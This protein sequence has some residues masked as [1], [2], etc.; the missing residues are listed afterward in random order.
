LP[1]S[2]F[3][4]RRFGFSVDESE[5]DTA[6]DSAEVHDDSSDTVI[7]ESKE[8]KWRING[9][10]VSELTRYVVFEHSK[11]GFPEYG[12]IVVEI[13]YEDSLGY[14]EYRVTSHNVMCKDYG[15]WIAADKDDVA[16]IRDRLIFSD[17]CNE[18]DTV[19]LFALEGNFKV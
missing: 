16:S 12:N 17:H 5:T 18:E 13:S 9:Y 4:Y 14:E 7:E 3:P 6:A 1:W 10:D 15:K 19:L 11:W 2:L 8:S